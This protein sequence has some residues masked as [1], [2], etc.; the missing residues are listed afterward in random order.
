MDEGHSK[1]NVLQ[2]WPP[3]SLNDAALPQSGSGPLIAEADS[4]N[5]PLDADLLNEMALFSGSEESARSCP[6]CQ[7]ECFSS[8]DMKDHLNSACM[9]AR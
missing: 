3:T 7:A 4:S 2:T 5:M 1:M 6:M 8:G 9:L